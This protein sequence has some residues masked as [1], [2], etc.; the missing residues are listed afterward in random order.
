[1]QNGTKSLTERLWWAPARRLSPAELVADGIVHGIGIVAGISI[2]AVVLALALVKTAPAEA[3]ALAVYLASLVVV[4]SVSMA[5]N[6]W[7]ISPIKGNLNI[8]FWNALIMQTIQRMVN[9]SQRIGRMNMP[10]NASIP[11]TAFTMI[12][13]IS[14][15]IA[16]KAWNRINLFRL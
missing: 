2:G 14:R 7:P 12:H 6:L 9:P 11:S 13:P 10:M 4:L 15:K 1:M 5:Y 3:P 16:W 8:W